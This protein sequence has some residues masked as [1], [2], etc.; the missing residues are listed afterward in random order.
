MAEP[1]KKLSVPAV[2]PEP[3]GFP[4]IKSLSE[5]LLPFVQSRFLCQLQTELSFPLISSNT[6]LSFSPP[7]LWV[8]TCE[9]SLILI[10]SALFARGN[11]TDEKAMAV[12]YLDSV[13]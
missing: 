9:Q 12:F 11:L 5:H 7:K 13:Q 6:S 1:V 4:L 3:Q 8:L 10:L 2:R